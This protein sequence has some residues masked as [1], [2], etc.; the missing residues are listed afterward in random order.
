M[1]DN[2]SLQKADHNLITQVHINTT[3]VGETSLRH[4]LPLLDESLP[5]VL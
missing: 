1:K 2:R 5:R 3:T 4:D